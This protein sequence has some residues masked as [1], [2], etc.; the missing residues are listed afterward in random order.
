MQRH[1]YH[2]LCRD[3]AGEYLDSVGAVL[4]LPANPFDRFWYRCDLGR[5]NVVLVEKFLGVNR[6]SAFG[7]ER[8]SYGENART[9][10]LSFFNSPPDVIGIIQDRRY[11][12]HRGKTP[13]REHLFELRREIAGR[14][15][16]GMK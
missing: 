9:G 11:V 10:H 1:R 16:L 5:R 4:N 13:A 2:A 3:G 8:V 14:T 6:G 12:E 7:I 15:F